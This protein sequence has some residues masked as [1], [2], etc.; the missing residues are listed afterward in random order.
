MTLR[1]L[2]LD[3]VAAGLSDIPPPSRLENI[4]RIAEFA[5]E[6]FE[7][8]ELAFP[9]ARWL[10]RAALGKAARAGA[11]AARVHARTQS[12]NERQAERRRAFE[13]AIEAVNA[14]RTALLLGDFTKTGHPLEPFDDRDKF[15]AAADE[16]EKEA[17]AQIA[18]IKVLERKLGSPGTAVK[19]A[20]ASA[21]AEAYAQ[22]MGEPLLKRPSEASPIAP[23]LRAVGRDLGFKSPLTVALLRPAKKGSGQD[24]F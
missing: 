21:V 14:S 24:D 10:P 19:R 20:V 15:R 9:E 17:L 13:T 22:G 7:V 23:L 1:R 5:E 11:R 16:F 2:R 3:D 18:M 12:W 4:A 8:D 6:R